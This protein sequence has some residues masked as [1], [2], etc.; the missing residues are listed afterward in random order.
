MKPST[1]FAVHAML[2]TS[3]LLC[4]MVRINPVVCKDSKCR[5]GCQCV[6][7]WSH[8]LFC[9]EELYYPIRL[10]L[11]DDMLNK[12][13]RRH[14]DIPDGYRSDAVYVKSVFANKLAFKLNRMMFSSSCSEIT[15]EHRGWWSARLLELVYQMW[16]AF[17]NTP[18]NVRLQE[19]VHQKSYIGSICATILSSPINPKT[20]FR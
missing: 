8:F 2:G 4:D 19:E 1:R 6:E 18:V 9:D 3:P 7:T 12:A 15:K 5:H 10:K 17:S 13:S 11:V 20:T 16:L 14:S